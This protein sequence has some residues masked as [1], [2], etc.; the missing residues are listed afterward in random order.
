MA[1]FGRKKDKLDEATKSFKSKPKSSK[2]DYGEGYEDLDI[3]STSLMDSLSSFNIFHENFI[4]RQHKNEVSKIESYRSMASAPE[5]A[6][7]LEDAIIESTQENEEGNVIKLE[8]KD[9]KLE[10]N[11]NTVKTIKEEF[12]DLFFNRLN[13]NDEIWNI[14]QT[15]F[16]DGKI[17]GERVG[18]GKN[19][20]TDLK[21]LPTTT[22][23]FKIGENGKI[24]F[25]VQYLNKNAKLPDTIED[26]EKDPNLIAFWPSQISYVNSGIFGSNRKDVLG[27][28]EKCKQPYNQLKLLET[29]V[30]IYRIIRAPERLVFRI[31][32]GNMPKD[33][34]LKYV[35]KLKKKF[36]QK[37]TYDPDSGQLVNKAAITSLLENFY[38]PQ[39]ADGRGSQID[40]IGGNF[41]SFAELDDI[42]YFQRKLYRSLKYPMSRVSKMQENNE[43]DMIFAGGRM[44]EITRDEIKWAKFLERQQNRI[45]NDLKDIFLLHLEFK[46]IRKEYELNKSSFDIEMTPPNHYKDQLEQLI[47][48]TKQ[49]NYSNLSTEEAFPKTWLMNKYMDMDED[50][51]KELKKWHDFDDEVLPEDEG[52]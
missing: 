1:I 4:N 45:I 5:I 40:T 12:D 32:T 36:Q 52:F 7:V 19:G 18:K 20:I 13:I 26:A 27:Y 16:T 9:E 6:D 15:Y 17:F 34:A 38:L 48:E 39:S 3:T 8:I 31:D 23:D 33:K 35:E 51:I 29:A 44:G 50:E 22:M 41:S 2:K 24:D 28:L 10:K 42:Y 43:G 21:I 37:S 46:G 25:F 11:E 14:L 47:L 49:N 30:I